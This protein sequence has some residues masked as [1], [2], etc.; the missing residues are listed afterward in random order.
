MPSI[1]EGMPLAVVEAM[2]CARPVLATDVGGIAEWIDDGS[3]GFIATCSSSRALHKGLLRM[4]Q[5]KD[6]WEK[7]GLAAHKTAMQMHN[8][9]AGEA[10]LD[11]LREVIEVQAS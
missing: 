1:M 3:N 5:L 6:N 4:W 2:L 11:K 8:P 9:K 10:L 7:I